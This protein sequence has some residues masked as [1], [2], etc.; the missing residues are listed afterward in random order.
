MS[1]KLDD[2]SGKYKRIRP[3][4]RKLM[5]R[6]VESLRQAASIGLARTAVHLPHLLPEF[7][8][9]HADRL[10]EGRREGFG[11]RESQLVGQHLYL[12][13]VVRFGE[14]APGLA[15]AAGVD[16]LRTFRRSR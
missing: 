5:F 14:Y 7:G 10:P 6:G 1:T 8:R 11:R 13:V 2:G 4:K 16:V 3:L 9:Q 15:D 12:Y